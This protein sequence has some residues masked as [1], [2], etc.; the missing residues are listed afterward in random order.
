MSWYRKAQED[1]LADSVKEWTEEEKERSI[2]SMTTQVIHA[3]EK[4]PRIVYWDQDAIESLIR[5]KME[6]GLSPEDTEDQEDQEE[7]EKKF[8]FTALLHGN[9]KNT[10]PMSWDLAI[11]APEF[12]DTFLILFSRGKVGRAG[13]PL[14]VGRY[15]DALADKPDTPAQKAANIERW[16]SR[17]DP[18]IRPPREKTASSNQY[19]EENDDQEI[20]RE[21]MPGALEE[22]R[23]QEHRAKLDQAVK[24]TMDELN[25]LVSHTTNKLDLIGAE[26]YIREKVTRWGG[27]EPRQCATLAMSI[28]MDSTMGNNWG[29]GSEFDQTP[30]EMSFVR[31]LVLNNLL[32]DKEDMRLALGI[33]N[34]VMKKRNDIFN[35]Q[36]NNEF[37]ALATIEY[38]KA[39]KQGWKLIDWLKNRGML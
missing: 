33:L 18:M 34:N 25:S 14:A 29:A 13:A 17:L 5:I 39:K 28:F 16:Y 10:L 36:Q 24:M 26:N 31:L 30:A 38:K 20:L 22:F 8:I 23:I 27:A 11:K 35:R 6:K 9:T 3:L 12:R 21:I 1:D 32:E 15:F 4:Y 7:L 2:I 19:D 37:L